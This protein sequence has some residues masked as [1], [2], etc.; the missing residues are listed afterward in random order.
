MLLTEYPVAGPP[1]LNSQ[2]HHRT[3][4]ANGNTRQDLSIMNIDSL[5][6]LGQLGI[7]LEIGGALYIA[8][9]TVTIH[10][11]IGRLF[12][13]IWGIRELPKLMGLMQGQARTDIR[14]FLMLA[15]GLLLQFVGNFGTA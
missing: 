13:N 10:S 9:S 11:R 2:A 7:L 6:L 3:W 15:A 5:W 14:G 1:T 8:M 12:N 4:A